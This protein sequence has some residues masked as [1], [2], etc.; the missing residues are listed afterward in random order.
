MKERRVEKGMY[1]SLSR[2]Q[3]PKVTLKVLVYVYLCDVHIVQ[4][5]FSGFYFTLTIQWVP[6]VE[7]FTAILA[8]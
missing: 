2:L 6:I 5:L 8:G 1:G 7:D 3:A 4:M